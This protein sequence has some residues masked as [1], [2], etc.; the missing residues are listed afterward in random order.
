MADILQITLPDGTTYNIKDNNALPLT[1]GQVTGPVTFGDSV[2]MDD[3]T[4]GNIIVTGS[5]SFVQGIPWSTITGAPT[6]ISGYGIT[7]AVTN[8]AYNSSTYN[9]TKTINN[10]TSNVLQMPCR[11]G[12]GINSLIAGDLANNIASGE[13]S[14]AAGGG[15]N[16]SGTIIY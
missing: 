13:N 16:I 8:V 7:D 11:T 5:S 1:G 2:L 9:I 10:T 14:F 4:V 12:T 15:G 6:T 3:L